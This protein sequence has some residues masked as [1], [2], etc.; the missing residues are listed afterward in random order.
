MHAI[1][2]HG[3]IPSA[4]NVCLGKVK[5]KKH[6][7]YMLDDTF[8]SVLS[9]QKQYKNNENTCWADIPAT[10]KSQA[11][12]SPQI[13]PLLDYRQ[14]CSP[15]QHC[16]RFQYSRSIV[17]SVQT[18]IS[19]AHWISVRSKGIFYLQNFQRYNTMEKYMYC[20]CRDVLFYFFIVA[21]ISTI[22]F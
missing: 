6:I 22:I 8:S 7:Q 20:H 17:L 14:L 12:L 3:K 4:L 19:R 11:V 18:G 13:S 15:G 21:L 1:I 10:L 5:K 16:L 2:H 9:L